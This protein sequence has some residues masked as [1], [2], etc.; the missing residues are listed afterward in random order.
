MMKHFTSLMG[1]KHM[2]LTLLML[3][4]SM[5]VAMA[6]NQIIT[7]NVATPGTL[8]TMMGETKK[9]AITALK[10]TGAINIDDIK[11]LREMAG[12]YY[13]WGKYPGKLEY[14]DLE[15]ASLNSKS[16]SRLDIYTNKRSYWTT[17]KGTDSQTLP[18]DIFAFLDQLKTIILPSDI[19]NIKDNVFYHNTSLTTVKLP[20]DLRSIGEFAFSECENLTD[21]TIPTFVEEI[22]RNAFS[23]CSSLTSIKI[24]SGVKAIA[25]STFENCSNLTTVSLP[26]SLTYVYNKAFQNDEK[27]E[28]IEFPSSIEFIGYNAFAGCSSLRT[29]YI[30]GKITRIVTGAFQNCTGIQTMVISPTG[31]NFEIGG[32]EGCTNLE[33]V[34]INNTVSTIGGAAFKGCSKLKSFT[35]QGYGNKLTI[36]G[37]AFEGCSSL[38]QFDFPNTETTIGDRAFYGCS[39]FKYIHLYESTTAIGASAFAQ[40]THLACIFVDMLNPIKIN[41]NVFEGVDKN[42]CVLF[43]PEGK[44]QPYWL[45]DVW[46]DFAYIVDDNNGMVYHGM[47]NITVETPGTLEYL[48]GS[49][50]NHISHLTLSG[51]LN[52]WDVQCL[53]E[54]AGCYYNAN[55]GK[56]NGTLNVL[57]LQKVNF[58]NLSGDGTTPMEIYGPNGE[59]KNMYIQTFQGLV[60]TGALFAYLDALSSVTLP[61][62]RSISSS[63]IFMHCPELRFAYIPEGVKVIGQ[64]TFEGCYNLQL[65]QTP[66][67]LTTINTWM[68]K[69]CS[70]LKD[71]ILSPRL[72]LIGYES[73]SGCSSLT[74]LK[75]PESVT[76]I[77]DRAYENCSGLKTLTLPANLETIQDEAFKGCTGLTYIEA[78]M[79]SPVTIQENTFA[80]VPCDKCPLIVPEGS[81]KAY[82]EAAVWNK[83]STITEKK[84]S[85]ITVVVDQAGTLS[86]KISSTDKDNISRLKVIGPIN[87]D[88]I[89]FLREMAG[90]WFEER[91]KSSNGSLYHL[92]L[93]G[94]RL[95]GSDKSINIY[96]QGWWN[97]Q[98]NRLVNTAK[99][100][101]NGNE[102]SLLFSQLIHLTSVVMPSY[103]TTT[104]RG[105]FIGSP[106]RSVS[107]SENVTTIGESCF[108]ECED[109]TSINLPAS[110]K[111]IDASAFNGCRR[112]TNI[113]LPAGLT[114]MGKG[115]FNGCGF[116]QFVVPDGITTISN[117]LFA[118]CSKLTSI[119]LPKS[120]KAIEGGAFMGC[121]FTEFVVP[122]GITTI[123]NYLFANC[124][125]LT[126]ITLPKGLKAIEQ[127]AFSG[128][129]FTD[130]VIPE[131]IT[132][133]S[134]DLFLNCSKLTSVTLPKGVTYIEEGAFSYSGIKEFTLP[135]Q[136][137]EITNDMFRECHNLEHINLHDGL[138]GI[139]NYAFANS[140]LNEINIPNSVSYLGEGCFRDCRSLSEVVIS[141][142]YIT[143]IPTEAFA[144]SYVDKIKLP[145]NLER[146]GD[147]AFLGAYNLGASEGLT[148]PSKVREI[149]SEAF[150]KGLGHA[151]YLVLPASLNSVPQVAFA[152]CSA[153][154]IYAYMTEPFALDDIDFDGL[155]RSECKLYVPKGCAKKYRQAE[156][157]KEFDIEEMDGTGIEGVTNDS[158]VTEEARYDANGNMLAAPAKGLNIVRYSDGTVKKVMVE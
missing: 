141:S 68:F 19:M 44:Y 90:C 63:E 137:T 22:G 146:I 76:E 145:A 45:A 117:D 101:P 37:S 109:L 11:F 2:L 36:G 67:T 133:I 59:R 130:F 61:E 53:R 72:S 143:E 46:G 112:L 93:D 32:F 158:T 131:G 144:S 129:G 78:N 126:S 98:A 157:W 33:S 60:A 42:A 8:N 120:L 50:K 92:D 89:Q 82:R 29:N 65:V 6:A 127:G 40:C 140:A 31:E 51:T 135:K 107:M 30:G 58:G 84:S 138:Q 52:I 27:L 87:I 38:K 155:P 34:T 122:D 128:C 43:V 85:C 71:V 49:M 9:Y 152:G 150:Y 69:G 104:G 121:G 23:G 115:A 95:V 74:L 139:G 103:L 119:T 88:D 14:L 100:E 153:D 1:K 81:A 99:I 80:N 96:I 64:S 57:D 116:T 94:A 118:N 28:N 26:S 25:E 108:S 147:R 4:C 86:T 47:F 114:S 21:L 15:G 149:G 62:E 79:K 83:F 13:N 48:L 110:V 154:V 12:C 106:I 10:L 39:E 156:V 123:S 91:D 75:L 16:G 142:D 77:C 24:P 3:L 105:T 5:R 113:G 124:D 134:K 18:T 35:A 102:F 132:T 136:I 17:V 70:N 111:N 97:D 151:A 56:Y 41:K 20:Y 66:S 54:M 7:I 73:F 148:I 55:G 125:K